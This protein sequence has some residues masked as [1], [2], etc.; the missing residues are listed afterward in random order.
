M[1]EANKNIAFQAICWFVAGAIA[2]LV[3]LKPMLY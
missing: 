3:V 2:Y 1:S